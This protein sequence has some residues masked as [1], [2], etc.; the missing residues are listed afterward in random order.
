MACNCNNANPNCEPCAICTPPGVTG[1]TTCQPVDPCEEK[2]PLE[3][4]LYSG[5]E[6]DCDVVVKTNDTVFSILAALFQ[7]FKGFTP[8]VTQCC[9]LTGTVVMSSTTTTA[10]P[11]TTT[12]TPRPTTTTSSTSTTTTVAP[13]CS[14]TVI[15][16]T[17]TP[18]AVVSYVPCNSTTPVQI[19]VTSSTVC[20]NNLYPITVVSGTV[21]TSN[22]GPCSTPAPPTTTSTTT[23]APCTCGTYRVVNNSGSTYTITYTECNTGRRLTTTSFNTDTTTLICGCNDIVQGTPPSGVVITNLG[24][25][26]TVTPTTTTTTVNCT[27][28]GGNVDQVETMTM[29]AVALTQAAVYILANT[30]DVYINWGDGTVQRIQPGSAYGSIVHNYSTPYT[31]DITY[32]SKSLAT[33]TSFYD[34]A[35]PVPVGGY[36]AFTGTSLTVT[37]SEFGKLKGLTQTEI[38]G[39]KITG[40]V[41]YLPKSLT[42][43]VAWSN[44]TLSGNVKDLP[45]LLTWINIL[46]NN[47]LTGTIADFPRPIVSSGGYGFACQGSNT[48]SGNIADLPT[49]SYSG[50]SLN[51]IGNNT[52]IGDITNI[53]SNYT[54]IFISGNN[55]LTGD[56]ANFKS[57]L[58]GVGIHGYNT[59]YGNIQSIKSTVVY[60]SIIGFNY[61]GGTIASL[62]SSVLESMYIDGRNTIT[63]SIVS[64]YTSAT[65]LKYL[66]VLGSNTIS[67]NIS[68]L[69][70]TL[71]SILL[72]GSNTV[73]GA[74][75]GLVPL[76]V[77]EAFYVSG[78]N[79]IS[80]DIGSLPSTIKG[81]GIEGSNTVNAYTRPHTWSAGIASVTFIPGTALTSTITDNLL[82]DLNAVPMLSGTLR[83]KGSTTTASDAA[84]AALIARGVTV[85][86]TP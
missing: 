18:A 82:I 35:V 4:V 76:T 53:P 86:I 9:T 84:K 60:F 38:V 43:F 10:A 73:S 83:L 64:L 70:R 51:L 55:V 32:I 39:I 14:Y 72:G 46:G 33:I 65:A 80:G 63:G 17:G 40:D 13:P 85:T 28:S 25:S 56:I 7:K 5:Q 30:A 6:Y 36:Q 69:S 11:T 37:T 54:N 27:N 20:V 58:I 2:V 68:G 50:C 77:L 22:A 26:C 59:L 44:N 81:V 34:Q 16:N 71:I 29:Q 15:T 48:I 49:T 75:S 3:C 74:L 45:R 24:I 42:Y 47:T 52:I 23:A 31:G 57:A 19:T 62:T 61:I 66:T 41:A 79:T 67:G 1:L 12:T 8:T 78:S 21:T